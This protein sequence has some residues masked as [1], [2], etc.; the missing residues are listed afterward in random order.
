MCRGKEKITL[1]IWMENSSPTLLKSDGFW[2]ARYRRLW[3]DASAPQLTGTVETTLPPA[4]GYCN[5]NHDVGNHPI[6][7]LWE[8][9]N[10][11]NWWATAATAFTF[12]TVAV[13]SHTGSNHDG[14]I[15]IKTPV[16]QFNI[17]YL[18]ELL[19]EWILW[20]FTEAEHCYSAIKIQSRP[21]CKWN[22]MAHSYSQCLRWYECSTL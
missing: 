1:T 6:H 15:Y 3:R 12:S 7:T 19:I 10:M 11:E 22:K 21:L 20:Y 17:G 5:P 18:P 8:V 13:S 14:N 9:M 2:L 16:A 4:G